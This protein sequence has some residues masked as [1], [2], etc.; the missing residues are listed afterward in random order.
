MPREGAA[1]NVVPFTAQNVDTEITPRPGGPTA[2]KTL[3]NKALIA[4]FS[5]ELLKPFAPHDSL[6][7]PAATQY[8][9]RE[10]VEPNPMAYDPKDYVEARL[11]EAAAD[12]RAAFAELGA[13]IDRVSESVD[14]KL[15]ASDQVF[16]A[17][18]TKF[19]AI[20]TQFEAISSTMDARFDAINSTMGAQFDAINSKM[21]GLQSAL[22]SKPGTGTV[23]FSVFVTGLTISG[24]MLAV[25]AFGGDRF[26]GGMSAAQVAAGAIAGQDER[27]EAI[28]QRFETIEGQL[29]LIVRE[30]TKPAE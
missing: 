29:D 30:I 16:G 12:N 27:F 28:D 25:L 17:M 7:E 23:L 18:N 20:N 9:G 24:L 1:S 21:E 19:D 8:S 10:R 26:N 13:K 11:R 5:D 2:R 6:N 14:A 22:D 4:A 3:W 15:S